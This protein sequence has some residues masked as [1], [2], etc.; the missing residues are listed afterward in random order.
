MDDGPR[1]GAGL[2][3]IS[4]A[5]STWS[6]ARCA[7]AFAGTLQ[8]AQ[9]GQKLRAIG[10]SSSCAAAVLQQCYDHLTCAD[11]RVKLPHLTLCSPALGLSLSL[12]CL[13]LKKSASSHAM[14]RLAHLSAV[15]GGCW[16]AA[17]RCGA[18]EG[19]NGCSTLARLARG[20]TLLHTE[21]AHQ[22]I[23][24]PAMAMHPVWSVAWIWLL[25]CADPLAVRL[26][27]HSKASPRVPL[28]QTAGLLLA[29]LEAVWPPDSHSPTRYDPP[30]KRALVAAI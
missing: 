14:H 9:A 21:C 27:A 22:R 30:S 13:V 25:Q 17:S 29:L 20:A 18:A 3:L 26:P 5:G 16:Q 28:G 24:S 12:R 4:N 23:G 6:D 2:K 19:V 15:A 11:C 7:A 1:A 8:Y 10:L